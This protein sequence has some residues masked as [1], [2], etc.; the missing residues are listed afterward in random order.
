LE[1]YRYYFGTLKDSLLL[2]LTPPEDFALIT[3][4]GNVRAI[5]SGD[6]NSIIHDILK[7]LI[8]DFV[9]NENY[10]LDK[11][12]SADIRHGVFENQLRSSAEKSQLITDM[13]S[14]E[15]YSKSNL[16]IETYPLM[17]PVIND[18]IGMAIADFSYKFDIELSK[19]NSWFNVKTMISSELE[20][21][22]ID[23]II[24]VDM[25]DAFKT[26]VL[27]HSS[28][29]KFFESCISFMWERTSICLSQIK[30]RLHSEFKK[31]IL[32]LISILRVQVDI[33]KRRSSMKEIQEKI[34]LLAESMNKEIAT[35]CDWL[36]VLE[37]NKDKIYKITSVLQACR[38][39][40]FNINHCSDDSIILDSIFH[41]DEPKLSYKEAK[42]LITSI[43]TALNN[44]MSYGDKKIVINIQPNENL[45]GIFIKNNII[46]T[47]NRTYEQILQEIDDKIKKGDSSLN[48][49]E[50][51]AGIYKIYDLLHSLPQRFQVG[52][53]IEN[54]EFI[55]NIEVN[56]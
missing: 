56:K 35:V 55:L 11:Y 7:E 29:E 54:N 9:K 48:T 33:Y 21:G 15:Q 32:D 22:M 20:Q 3:D 26:K 49:K 42:P 52:H 18:E 4:D 37:H 27:G 16:I 10:G 2:G 6:T 23:F 5:P 8:S 50:G 40:F 13:D 43:I 45:W 46:E 53:Y 38:K 30:E 14:S 39:T 12:L 34:D 1:R 17:N 31:N 19:A 36:N 41:D 47:K 51:G 28:F 44:A 25:F 24:S